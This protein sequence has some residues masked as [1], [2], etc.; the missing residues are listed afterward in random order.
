MILLGLVFMGLMPRLPARIPPSTAGRRPGWS[1][2]RCSA[3]SSASAG[4]RASAPP[5]PPSARSRSTEASAG[6][7]A[8]LT[9]AYCLGLGLPFVLAALA[10]RRA[11]GAFGWVKRHYAWVMRIGG[12]MMIALGCCSSPAS[13]TAWCRDAGLVPSF[14][15]GI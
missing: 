5:S 11:L 6:R 15:V 13:G 1:A 7:G 8:L 3:R 12:G 14:T 2:R 9:V 10:F 4:R